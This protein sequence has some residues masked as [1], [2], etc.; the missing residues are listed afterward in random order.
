MKTKTSNTV[1]ILRTCI[2]LAVALLAGCSKTAPEHP[3]VTATGDKVILPVEE[4][5]DGIVRFFT[6]K[7]SGKNV[8]FFVRTDKNGRIHTHFD[9]C[10]GCYQYKMGYFVDGNDIVCYACRYRYNLD[11]EIW[12]YIGACAPI[13]FKHKIRNGN[14]LIDVSVPERGARFF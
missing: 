5:G 3:I 8:N 1:V 2:L 11:E 12:D 4:V 10:Y 7:Y 9:A 14:L 13:T 6:Y